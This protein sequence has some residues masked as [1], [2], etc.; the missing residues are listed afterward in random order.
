[1]AWWN[2]QNLFD[3]DD[4]PISAD[5]EFT[6]ANGW[7]PEVF[8]AKKANLA[9]VLRTLHDGSPPELLGV[10]EVEGDGVFKQLLAEVGEPH[11]QV[12][13]DPDGTRDLRG[14]DVSLAFDDR[15]LTPLERRSHLVHLRFSTRDI[16]EVVFRINET[17][18]QFVVIASHWPSRRTGRYESEPFRIAVAENIA[19][20]VRDH[21]RFDAEK[22]LALRQEGNLD[23][24][25]QRFETPIL[26]I[27]DFNDEPFDRSVVSHLQASSERDRVV[28]PTN[29][30][31]K[32]ENEAST[33][34]NDDTFLYNAS[35]K[36]LEPENVGTFFL[37]S[38]SQGEAFANRYQMLDQLVVSRGLLGPPGLE[39]DVDSVKI[40]H[41]RDTVATDLGRPRPFKKDT[42]RGFSDHLPVTATLGY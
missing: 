9:S 40:F 8:A 38:T 14:I 27:G 7:T 18:E 17:G 29:D 11:L 12:V 19:F 30:I 39:L 22:Y 2:L 42:K 32:F 1:V 37:D 41:D 24:V 34:R 20:L 25:K 5:L 16:F 33:Y 3:T 36:F 13:E 15:K 6:V 10:C 35:W 28:G 26:V 21:V 31:D 4:D 23:A